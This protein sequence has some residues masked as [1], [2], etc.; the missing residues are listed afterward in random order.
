MTSTYLRCCSEEGVKSQNFH[1]QPKGKMATF[2]EAYQAACDSGLLPGVV[3]LA[4]SS[5]GLHTQETSNLHRLIRY[6]QIQLCENDWEEV[7]KA[8]RV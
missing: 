6:R 5:N 8:W 3:L 2:E 4:S 7:G 1:Y